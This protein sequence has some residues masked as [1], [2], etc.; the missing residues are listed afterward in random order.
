VGDLNRVLPPLRDQK[1]DSKAQ[2]TQKFLKP[3]RLARSLGWHVEGH[4]PL[5][6]DVTHAENFVRGAKHRINRKVPWIDKVNYRSFRSFVR[7]WLRRNL[8]PLDEDTDVSIE[9]WLEKTKY[10]LARKEELRKANLQEDR[11]MHLNKSFIKREFYPCP[12]HARLINSRSDR[13]KAKTGPTFHQIE[14]KVF[15]LPYFVKKIPVKDRSAYINN[16]LYRPGNRY[17]ATDH[18][19]FEAHIMPNIMRI[20]EMQ[21]YS[22]MTKKLK[23]RDEFLTL[24]CDGLL[25][26]QICVQNGKMY[27]GKV[28][29][30]ARM[31]GDMC[32]SLGNGFTNLM[33]MFFIAYRKGWRECEGVVEGDDGLFRITGD[34]PTEDD[35]SEIGFT[36]KAEIHNRIGEAG[37]CQIYNSEDSL[38]NLV[39]PQKLL[40]RSGWTMSPMLHGSEKIMASLSRSKA[41]SILAE[42]PTNPITASMAKW[43]LRSTVGSN[44]RWDR[45][46]TW[47][48]DQCMSANMQDILRL[49]DKGPTIGQRRFVQWKWNIGV[50]TQLRIERYFDNLD[51]IQPIRDPD[52]I[53]IVSD[54][55]SIWSWTHMI[56]KC[57]KGESWG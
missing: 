17:M 21:L 19:S 42:A 46:E 9:G 4:S 39:Q 15:D 40:L 2:A 35:F 31:S 29:T 56:E 3:M 13:F 41:Y 48:A 50:E 10:T 8:T 24:I 5:G 37:F 20:C 36:V 57:H 47:W 26:E 38:E 27:K 53:E 22:Y 54:T 14:D 43:I 11:N 7:L 28:K 44:L 52:V 23:N 34:T 16:L 6:P 18:T 45:N 1:T 51:G 25:D 55:W 30:H 12:K 49:S 32:T 33:V